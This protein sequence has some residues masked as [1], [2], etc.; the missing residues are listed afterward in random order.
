MLT[1]NR[2]V[3]IHTDL[4]LKEYHWL[5][6]T[7]FKD[8]LDV[9][10]FTFTSDIN[11]YLDHYQHRDLEEWASLTTPYDGLGNPLYDL[12]YE[13]LE[14]FYLYCETIAD[15]HFRESVDDWSY[16][17]GYL[18]REHIVYIDASPI[19]GIPPDIVQRIQ[20]D[21]EQLDQHET[22]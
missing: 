6:N 15:K 11:W 16:V 5:K 13:F 21:L 8:F 14:K 20:H 9:V 19:S 17:Y 12:R 2:I 22:V 1:R 7:I 3:P 10:D 18:D 4:Y